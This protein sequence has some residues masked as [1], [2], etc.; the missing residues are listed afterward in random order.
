MWGRASQRTVAAALGAAARASASGRKA[1][2]AGVPKISVTV[3]VSA[4]G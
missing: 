1:G 3:R 4:Q 2:V